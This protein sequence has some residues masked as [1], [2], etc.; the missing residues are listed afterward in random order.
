MRLRPAAET[1]L[2]GKFKLTTFETYDGAPAGQYNVMV[3]W[4]PR[5]QS[6]AGEARPERGKRP[7][8]RLRGRYMNPQT[9]G[10]TATVEE[11][12]TEVP[13]FELQSR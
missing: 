5:P 4:G 1:G 10:L 3:R 8:D 11:Q 2:D 13:A 12:A 6:A 7:P 9:S